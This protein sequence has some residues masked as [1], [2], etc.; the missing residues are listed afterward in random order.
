[1]NEDNL[2]TYVE[3]SKFFL[4]AGLKEKLSRTVV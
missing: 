1:M 2:P 4:K 3:D